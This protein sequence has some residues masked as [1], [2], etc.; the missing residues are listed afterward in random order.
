MHIPLHYCPFY[1]TSCISR[2]QFIIIPSMQ[3]TIHGKPDGIRGCQLGSTWDCRL[4]C[5]WLPRVG[6]RLSFGRDCR[7]REFQASN[8]LSIDIVFQLS[9]LR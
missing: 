8:V 6:N 1:W 2:S 4:S 9:P 7:A 3:C 5:E